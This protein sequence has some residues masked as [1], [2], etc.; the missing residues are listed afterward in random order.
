MIIRM[1]YNYV[2]ANKTDKQTNNNI[3]SLHEREIEAALGIIIIIIIIII[4]MIT[5]MIKPCL[6]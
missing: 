6:I 1:K 2:N 5:V 4:I 3:P